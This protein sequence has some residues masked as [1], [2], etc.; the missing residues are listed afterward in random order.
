MKILITGGAGFIG[1]NI[2]EF[3][4][5]RGDTV[6]A[7]D[8]FSTG[9]RGNVGGFGAGFQLVREDLLL[10]DRLVEEA[11][12]ADRIYHMAAVVGMFRVLEEPVRVTRVNVGATERV[13][14]AAALGGRHP[15]V[16]IA[17]SSSVYGRCRQPEL[18]EDAELVYAPRLG[19]LTG[20]AIS[21]LTNEVQAMAYAQTR[22]IKVAIP[23]LFNAVGSRQTGAYG[24]VLPRFLQQALSSRPLTVFGDGTQTR[25]FCDVRDTVA[26]LDLLASEPAARGTPV[27][28]GNPREISILEL[29]Q[30]VIARTGSA[31]AIEF[32]PYDLAYGQKFDQVTQRR[33][34]I[35]KLQKLT[36][37]AAR[38]GLEDTIDDLV[39][40][41][42]QEEVCA[43]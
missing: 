8:D 33:P 28:V 16:V 1:S 21:K 40:A 18:R 2:A 23:R 4:L 19:G 5:R 17:S 12:K 42:H 14:E 29:A 32:I 20:Y 13:L 9:S 22:G 34:V 31:S 43:A 25:S 24:F 7:V 15:E 35:D 10:W 37:F 36:G 6:V 30:M 3:H 27:N 39:R 38:H 11:A 26:A 41:R